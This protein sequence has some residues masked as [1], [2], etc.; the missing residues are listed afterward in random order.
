MI[1][2]TVAVNLKDC[3][4]FASLNSAS[5]TADDR[6][7]FDRLCADGREALKWRAIGK[8][9]AADFAGPS[10][11]TRKWPKPNSARAVPLAA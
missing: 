8:P 3:P 11:W 4:P 5:L 9:A 10:R 2:N 1:L 6:E 7:K